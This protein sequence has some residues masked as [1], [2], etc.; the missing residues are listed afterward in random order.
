MSQVQPL[1]ILHH[2]QQH[3]KQSNIEVNERIESE[4]KKLAGT[5]TGTEE[6]ENKE[7]PET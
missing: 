4:K 2:L 5:S 7:P 6:K 3:Y 1:K